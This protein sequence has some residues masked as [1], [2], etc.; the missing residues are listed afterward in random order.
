M[1]F[2]RGP[3][4]MRASLLLLLAIAAPAAAPARADDMMVTLKPEQI[5]QIF[6]LSR[7]GNDEGPIA[8]LLSPTLASAIATARE[9]NAA[10]ESANP[11]EKP[12]LGDG[13]PWQSWPDY[14]PLC[15]VGLVTLMQSDA[16][17]EITYAF[18]DQPEADFTDTLLL[19]R[20]Q[21]PAHGTGLWRLDNIAFGTGGDL[22]DTLTG[23]FDE[24]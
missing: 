23:V 2:L 15:A 12:P 1:H 20:V 21:M 19:K 6:C 4:L 16:K 11:G 3:F 14:A 17:V 9:R 7:T 18:P 13:V 10:W 24:M 5:G 8:G 22:V